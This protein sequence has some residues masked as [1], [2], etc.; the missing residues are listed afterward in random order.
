M[1]LEQAGFSWSRRLT[2]RFYLSINDWI[3]IYL[4]T[5]RSKNVLNPAVSLLLKLRFLLLVTAL[6]RH[7]DEN[8]LLRRSI[9]SDSYLTCYTYTY[10]GPVKTMIFLYT[11]IY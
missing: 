2:F 4:L 6:N 9:L 1:D 10:N 11:P 8:M 7:Q 3:C 5:M